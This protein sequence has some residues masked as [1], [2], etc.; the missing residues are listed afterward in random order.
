MKYK[1]S[2]NP[3]HA[4]KKEILK[5]N[6]Q[7]SNHTVTTL[8]NNTRRKRKM[9]KTEFEFRNFIFA[10]TFKYE[11]KV[12]VCLGTCKI[13]CA[14]EER[15]FFAI[16]DME[17]MPPCTDDM[18]VLPLSVLETPGTYRISSCGNE[19]ELTIGKMGDLS[20][21]MSDDLTTEDSDIITYSFCIPAIKTSP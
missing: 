15:L 10:Q 8:S 13:P 6:H 20:M 1:G 2:L 14:N 12:W 4:V 11:Q 3:I 21:R 5:A 17:N 16:V 19:A 9:F 7:E 18:L